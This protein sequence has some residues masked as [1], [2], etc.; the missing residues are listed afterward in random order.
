MTREVGGSSFDLTIGLIT[1]MASFPVVLLNVFIILAIGQSRELRKPS[2]IILSSMAVTDLLVGAIVMPVYASIDLFKV[3]Q[4]SFRHTCRLFAINMFFQP[5]LFTS[6]LHHLTVIAWE[7]YVAVQKC[8]DYKAII[9]NGRLKKIVIGIWLSALF[10]AVAGVITNMVIMDRRLFGKFLTWWTAAETVCIFLVA[11][12]YRKVYLG[13]R[14]RRLNNI[15]QIDVVM[16]IK[17]ESKVAKTTGF[18]TAAVISFFIPMFVFGLFGKLVSI[19][20]TQAAHRLSQMVTQLNSLV[21]PLIYCYR[22]HRLR[23][24]ILELLRMRKP[25]AITSAVGNTQFARKKDSFRSLELLKGEKR[26]RRLTRSASCNLTDALYSIHRTP[27]VIKLKK[28]LSA[29][30]LNTRSGFLHVIDLHQPSSFVETTAMIHAERSV[31]TVKQ[32][33]TMLEVEK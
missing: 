20:N 6:T 10:P 29:P 3:S 30:T 16:K 25:Q 21:N 1:V 27:R 2:N 17:L 28:S 22:D 14:N 9:T 8:M 23:N 12:F 4:V 7:R 15:S 33:L 19:L 31:Q 32:G 5:L 24:T 26:S 18:L 11:F 13:I